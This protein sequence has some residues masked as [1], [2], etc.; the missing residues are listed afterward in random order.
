MDTNT[1][2]SHM[3]GSGSNITPEIKGYLLETAKWGKF[4]SIVGFVGIGFMILGGIFFSTIMANLG[5]MGGEEFGA[6]ALM[7]TG[8]MSAI[9]IVIAL[10][11]FFPCLYLYRFSTKIKT[12]LNHNDEAFLTEAFKNL[13]SIFK[14]MGIFTA[15]IL[16]FYAF[17][18]VL[19]LLGGVAA[20]F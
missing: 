5:A 3:G 16:G 13:K 9:Y 18:I 12:A 17:M 8:F 2:D 11:Y 20:M 6:A 4:L 1:L 14:F 7:G 10:I 15:V 19:G